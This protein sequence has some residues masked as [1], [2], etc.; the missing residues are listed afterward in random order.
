MPRIL[1]GAGIGAAAG[2]MI[3]AASFYL[4]LLPCAA[5]PGVLLLERLEKTGVV[6]SRTWESVGVY[7]LVLVNLLSYAA[8]GGLISAMA[9]S[10]RSQ[11]PDDLS[12]HC[13]K[14]KYSLRGIHS[15][16]CPECGAYVPRTA[17]CPPTPHSITGTGTP[18]QD[19][20]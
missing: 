17:G 19:Q 3:M 12:P 14:C 8:V 5:L 20:R 4:G 2:A 7:A 9:R 10:R 18:S 6:P 16:R 13:P 11:E 15:T 1:K